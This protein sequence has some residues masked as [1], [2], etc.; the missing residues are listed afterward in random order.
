MVAR[1]I[2]LVLVALGVALVLE[3]NPVPAQDARPLPN[4]PQISPRSVTDLRRRLVE[5]DRLLTLRS[6][7]RAEKLMEDLAMHSLLERE[8]IPRRIRLAQLRE[9]HPQAVDLARKALREE[10]LNAGLWRSLTTSL[11]AV[12]RPDSARLAA[13]RFISTSPNQ[14]SSGMVVVE[15]FQEAERPAMAVAL[16]DSLRRTLGD[17]H[18]LARQKAVELLALG[19]EKEAADEAVADLRHNPFNLALVRAELLD[20]GYLDGHREGFLERLEE[21]S[22]EPRRRVVEVLLAANLL[23]GDGQADEAVARVLPLLDARSSMNTCLQNAISLAR[24]LP[25]LA[26][27]EDR[28]VETSATTDYLLEILGRLS[29]EEN[30][31]PGLRKRA[32]DHLASVCET[33]LAHRVLGPDP[34]A[35]A[36]RFG[37][38]LAQVARAN[39]MSEHL[40]S[41]QIKLAAYMRDELGQPRAA[42]RRLEGMLLDLDMP[43][44]GVA[45]VRLTLGEC[46]LAAGDTTR[47]RIVLTRLGRD[48]QFREAGGH[49]HYHLARL[50]LAQ[51]HLATAQD[52]FAV[53]ALDNPAAPYA[54]DALELGLAIAEEMDN[55]SGG[56]DFILLYSQA[57]YFDLA[58]QPEKRVQALEH[59]IEVGLERLDMEEP[60]HLLERARWELA[61]AYAELD[62]IDDAVAV[63][64]GI[65]RDHPEGRFPAEALMLQSDL[66]R[67]QGDDARARAALEQLLAQYPDFLFVDDARDIL[68]SLP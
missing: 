26:E 8:L 13:G 44:P 46:Y 2:P 57:V 61:Q 35:A 32:A 30:Y 15:L 7:G 24:E 16:I 51:G 17:E 11:L 23:L 53:V 37:D 66:L 6:V 41:G 33:A 29:G 10:P 48:P 40:Y 18:F 55:A 12:D 62:R 27:N 1:S 58:A 36:D 63:C 60:Q 3:A 39:P 25:L 21:R 50:D 14:R 65:V 38:L 31:D 64:R 47:G 59:F 28:R 42:A 4:H 54:N 22:R 67:A 43:L 45:L 56:P 49:A 34:E 9:D 68:R 20:S 52:R 5:L 19:R